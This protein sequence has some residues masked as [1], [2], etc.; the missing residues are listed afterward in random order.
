MPHGC[1]GGDLRPKPWGISVRPR[2]NVPPGSA[3][4]PEVATKGVCTLFR[5]PRGGASKMWASYASDPR[6]PACTHPARD[7]SFEVHRKAPQRRPD[8]TLPLSHVPR[9]QRATAT[10]PARLEEGMQVRGIQEGMHVRRQSKNRSKFTG[11]PGVEIAG[12][13]GKATCHLQNIPP[14][15]HRGSRNPRPPHDCSSVGSHALTRA[16]GS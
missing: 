8:V 2:R 4:V 5:P 12:A 14:H 3:T 11:G 13:H 7:P 9:T 15:A 10:L 6:N 1:D 16:Q